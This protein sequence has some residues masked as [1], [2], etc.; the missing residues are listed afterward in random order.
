[1]YNP[2]P[3]MNSAEEAFEDADEFEFIEVTNTG[4]SSVWLA[5][6]E[7]TDGIEF[8]FADGRIPLLSVGESALIVK[9]ED[10]FV[11]RYGSGYPIAGE[12]DGSLKNS[13][14]QLVLINGLG[15][16]VHD[17]QYEDGGSW[18]G[19]ADG[20]GSSLT[21]VDPEAD[22]RDGDNWYSSDY[23][24]GTPGTYGARP[25]ADIIVNEVLTHTDPP[26]SDSI[27][28]FNP[29]D[30]AVDVSG[31]YLSDSSGD[32]LKFEIPDGT[33]IEPGDY[34]VFN[35]SDFNASGG[36][37]PKDF[38][39]SSAEG[40]D[41]WLMEADG[42]G[43]LVRFADHVEFPAAYNGEA[44]GRWPNATGDLYP[45]VSQT[46]GS[47]NSGP[48]VGP[49][50]ISEVNYNPGSMDNNAELEFIEIHNTSDGTVDMSGWRL[51]GEVDFDFTAGSMLGSGQTVIVVGFDP[52]DATKLAAFR[53]YYDDQTLSPVGPWGDEGVAQKLDNGGARITLYSTDDPPAE[54]PTT[55]PYCI[56][57]QVNYD[58][59]SPWPESADGSGDS[60]QRVAADVWGDDPASW[61][62]AA[63]TPGVVDF[64]STVVTGDL[65]G[66]GF[67]GG[68]DLDII[69][70][71]WGKSVAAGSLIDGDPT[72]DGVVNSND[73]DVVR[74][75]W[76]Q[77]ETPAARGR[78]IACECR[79]Y[80]HC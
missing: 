62:G 60:L 72:G 37:D 9:N 5:G 38:A 41:V 6:Y 30:A 47:E 12:Y 71:N 59:V 57:D 45:M 4:S 2:Y 76:G 40:D 61:L 3:P 22:Y 36:V 55:I 52:S 21:V 51:R 27:E 64:S 66:D 1:M 7:F 32:Y 19:R 31:W 23:F 75:N 16:T 69:R 74:A 58:D 48:R 54:D 33:V 8:E 53:D 42:A 43:N 79:F 78:R 24:G 29:T 80:F 39:L 73:L 15:Q 18:P 65:N 77:G 67:V 63:P 50:I 14:E 34:V 35:E 44:F 13:G 28:L 70:G 25:A 49:T 68:A 56:E 46:L 10:A 26:S 11:T 17:F 20:N